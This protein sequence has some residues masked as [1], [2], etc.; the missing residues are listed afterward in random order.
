[1]DPW[2]I[3]GRGL[4]WTGG[5]ELDR[6]SPELSLCG[7]TG[8]QSSPRRH[9]EGEGNGA[10]LTEA[11]IGQHGGE[12]APAAERNGTQRRCLVLGGSGHG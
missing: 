12:V 7:A 1:M 10:E 3:F 11:K 8:H 2:T 4:R 9:G 6:S 5:T